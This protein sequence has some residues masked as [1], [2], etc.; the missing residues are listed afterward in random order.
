MGVG[1]QRH[2]PA[3]LPPGE[4]RYP[5]YRRL[6]GPQGRS[7]RVRKMSPQPG[8]D[9]RTVQPVA[10][11]TDRAIPACVNC[12]EML[13]NLQCFVT[14]GDT[15]RHLILIPLTQTSPF[16]S[17]ELRGPTQQ[18]LLA[19]G[20][21]V[22]NFVTLWAFNK[23][24]CWLHVLYTHFVMYYTNFMTSRITNF[25]FNFHTWNYF[26]FGAL[27]ED[28]KAQQT[29]WLDHLK[30]MNMNRL[31]SLALL[32]HPK[33]RRDIGRPRRRWKD[34]EHVMLWRDIWRKASRCA[35]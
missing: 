9:P 1:G 12:T 5:L 31:P 26:C 20:I 4:T 24:L 22:T 33:G 32:Y 27:L 2:A 25:L 6:S 23:W 11:H 19:I 29:N 30:R 7:G 18:P 16:P 8:F 17:C 21:C 35:C 15:F 14:P 13:F 10:S 34:E 3:A 28:L